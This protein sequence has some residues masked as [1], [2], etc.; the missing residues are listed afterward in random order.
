[1]SD[2]SALITI[3]DG[4]MPGYHA[5]AT[6]LALTILPTFL[7]FTGFRFQWRRDQRETRQST[8]DLMGKL[9]DQQRA[10]LERLIEEL[11]ALR[12]QVD[13]FIEGRWALQRTLDQLRDQVIAA[14][15]IIHDYERR[16]GVPETAFPS[17]PALAVIPRAA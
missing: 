6:L 7:W 1:M 10:E 12:K 11:N 15:I 13:L 16:L 8:A 17:L 9:V 5:L 4:L 14:R 3:L 2:Q